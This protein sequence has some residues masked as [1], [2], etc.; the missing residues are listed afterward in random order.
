MPPLHARAQYIHDDE[1]YYLH[2]ARAV[3]GP[4]PQNNIVNAPRVVNSY[5]WSSL[6]WTNNHWSPDPDQVTIHVG[7]EGQWRAANN[8]VD[9]E[10]TRA[11]TQAELA[12]VTSVGQLVGG[13]YT[14][15]RSKKRTS[16]K[17]KS[18]KRRKS[19]KR[20]YKRKRSKRR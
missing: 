13:K 4:P 2:T 18:T 11:P 8:V 17:R 5:I 7:E 20:K 1:L 16:T 6:K 10:T 19:K 15:R 3:F 9:H 12:T 14:K